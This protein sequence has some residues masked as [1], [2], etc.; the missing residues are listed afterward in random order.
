MILTH[1][2]AL[3]TKKNHAKKKQRNAQ[4]KKARKPA[5]VNA[6]VFNTATLLI[7]V[8]VKMVLLVFMPLRKRLFVMRI[9]QFL[10]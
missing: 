10:V 4:R 5:Y 8:V 9:M 1:N 6:C 3:F 7:Y 2:Y